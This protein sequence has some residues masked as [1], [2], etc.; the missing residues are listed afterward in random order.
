MKQPIFLAL[1][2]LGGLYAWQNS[3]SL[4]A[5]AS[6]QLQP[7]H[8]SPYVAIYGRNSCSFT[9]STLRSLKQHNVNYQYFIVDNPE[10]AD[11]LHQRMQ[12]SGLNTRHY[13]LPVVD[14]SGELMIR[15]STDH[16]IALRRSQ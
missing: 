8:D 7:L 4:F 10:V 15:P 3:T 16:V 9:K 2:I 5:P 12:Q 1:M 13:N 14:V 11:S 6:N